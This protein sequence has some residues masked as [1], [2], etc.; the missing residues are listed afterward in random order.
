MPPQH[1]TPAF[2][3]PPRKSPRAK[4][5]NAPADLQPA[6]NQPVP[7]DFLLLHHEIPATTTRERPDPCP[8]AAD[9]FPGT[10][11][12]VLQPGAPDVSQDGRSTGTAAVCMTTV[13]TGH[14]GLPGGCRFRAEC[15]WSAIR[16]SRQLSS[17]RHPGHRDKKF[18][19]WTQLVSHHTFNGFL[20]IVFR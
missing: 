20:R 13:T 6:K 11:S 1:E 7:T 14:T 18:T 17:H 3:H 9:L 19:S 16:D 12:K 2:H 15:P 8:S 5:A 10:P 4:S